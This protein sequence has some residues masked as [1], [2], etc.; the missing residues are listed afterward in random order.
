MG[1]ATVAAEAPKRSGWASYFFKYAGNAGAVETSTEEASNSSTSLRLTRT[2]SESVFIDMPSS[3][4]REQ[5]GTNV[6]EPSNSTTHTR[7]TFTGVRLSRK[8]SVGVSMPALRAASRMVE[9]SGTETAPPS[10][11]IAMDRRGAAGGAWGTGPRGSGMRLDGAGGFSTA[12][13]VAASSGLFTKT[14]SND[15]EPTPRHWKQFDQVHKSK[16]RA[17][18]VRFRARHECRPSPN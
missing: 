11:L 15:P 14:S 18:S 5:A 9:P 8:Q 4:L 17:S 2:R 7:Q 12:G 10:I 3:T 1:C 6:R 13:I 16:R